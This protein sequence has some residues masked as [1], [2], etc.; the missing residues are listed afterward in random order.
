MNTLFYGDNLDILQKHIADASVDLIYLDPPFNSNR[1]YNALFKEQSGNESPAQI[2]AFGDT[3]NWAGAAESWSNFAAICPVPKVI[4]LMQGF[5]DAIGEN[6][7]L[8]YLVMMA[9]RLYHLHRVLKPTGS[10]YLHVDPTAGHY[11]KLILDGIFGIKNFR[12]EIIWHYRKWSVAQEQFVRN[13]DVI[14]FY[15]K[16]NNKE[17][18]FNTLYMDRAESTKKRFGNQKI[19]SGHDEEGNRLPSVTE[20]EESLGVAMDD[21]WDIPRV[22]PIKQLYPTQ[23]P[24]ALLERIVQASS[25]EGDLV[26]DPFCGCGTTVMAAQKLKRHW[27]GIDIT[28]IAT[29]LIQKRLADAFGAKPDWLKS[30]E[31]PAATPTFKV[32]GL[33]T[34]VA[35]ARMMYADPT[36]PTHK[37]FEMWAVGLVPAIPQEKKGADGGIDGVAYFYD[38]GKTPAKAIIQVKG[39]KVG[40]P[41]V[42]QL[43]GAMEKEKATLGFFLSLEEPTKNME[44]EALAAGYYSPPLYGGKRKVR[45]LQIRTIGQLLTGD[46]FDFPITGANVTFKQA[47][48]VQEDKQQGLDL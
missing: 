33:P 26:L 15:S 18:V 38:G 23:K 4:E 9:P 30:T 7:V 27:I 43:R 45:A 1:N 40:A 37:K 19:K 36:D 22:P 21:V 34:D 39:G 6:D 20:D 44:A 13:H 25:K 5:H 46:G 14:Y 48:R 11:L 12:N 31:D 42:Q 29:A 32:E 35:G 41:A 16:S 24:E 8:A 17:R 28:P 47:E 10:L 2:K 3:W